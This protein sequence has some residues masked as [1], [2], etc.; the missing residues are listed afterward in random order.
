MLVLR[1][2]EG[3]WVTITHHSGDVMRVRVCNVRPDYP[4]QVDLAF[5]DRERNFL[6]ERP[7]RV[8]MVGVVGDVVL[9]AH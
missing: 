7:E 9:E 3:S 1:R 6:I 5:D 8:K 2:K 4:G